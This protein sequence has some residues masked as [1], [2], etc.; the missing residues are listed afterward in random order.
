MFVCVFGGGGACQFS[1]SM[2]IEVLVVISILNV[3]Q[4]NPRHY[5]HSEPVKHQQDERETAKGIKLI[6]VLLLKYYRN[7]LKELNWSRWLRIF[8]LPH[9]IYNVYIVSIWF[10]HVLQWICQSILRIYFP[11]SWILVKQ[12]FFKKEEDM[13]AKSADIFLFPYSGRI[14]VFLL[15]HFKIKVFTSDSVSIRTHFKA[16]NWL[17]EH[18]IT[19]SDLI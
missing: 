4:C 18:V 9:A 19:K 17:L 7:Q 16:F 15:K 12:T 2:W 6:E 13:F 5:I 8:I 1:F 11:C 3:H 10:K 14:N